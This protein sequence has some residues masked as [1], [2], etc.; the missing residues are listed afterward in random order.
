M[1]EEEK[2]ARALKL[3]KMPP[4]KVNFSYVQNIY[5][6]KQ[7]TSFRDSWKRV[8]ENSIGTY[9]HFAAPRFE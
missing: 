1:K 9:N 3:L 2:K 4:P 5:A 6:R 7:K 8:D